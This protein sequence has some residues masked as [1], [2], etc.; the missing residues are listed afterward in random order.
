MTMNDTDYL[1]IKQVSRMTRV[2]PY[3]LRFWE[4]EFDGMLAPPRTSG[5]QRRYT[6]E[7]VE[8]IERIKAFKEEGF[9]L[10]KI[11]FLLMEKADVK[12]PGPYEIELLANRVAEMVRA[13]VQ[14]FLR[15]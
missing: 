12:Q 3:T 7:D 11:R 14:L 1:T 4:K 10:S 13:E 9:S 15:K 6:G 5:G 2:P 8:V